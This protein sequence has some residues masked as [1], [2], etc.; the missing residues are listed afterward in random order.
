M[1]IFTVILAGIL[2]IC[3]KAG[4]DTLPAAPLVTIEGTEGKNGWYN[5]Y[6]AINMEASEEAGVTVLYKLW[7]IYG[8]DPEPVDGMV[9]DINNPPRITEDGVYIL[10]V[11][12]EDSEG[13]TCNDKFY[14]MFKVDAAAPDVEIIPETA[15]QGGYYT[16]DVKVNL[17]VKDAAALDDGTGSTGSFFSV[18]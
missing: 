17:T 18:D 8:K 7:N 14:E 12:T 4:A 11:W 16:G 1:G 5:V 10:A 2:L 13:H 3:M 15:G 9:F 6:P